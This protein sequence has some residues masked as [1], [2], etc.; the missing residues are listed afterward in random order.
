MALVI[1]EWVL[2]NF[3]LSEIED[4]AVKG[5]VCGFN[6]ITTYAETSEFHDEY[7]DEIWDMLNEDAQDQGITIM[8][9]IAQFHGK[10]DV[11]SMFQF[12]NLL[13]WYAVERVAY[14][15]INTEDE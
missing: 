2:K 1:R 9:L 6:G 3:S 12:K 4:I 10:K 13:C 14:E 5:C 8:D 15:I 11:G 7:E